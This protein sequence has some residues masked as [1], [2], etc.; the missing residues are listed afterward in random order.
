VD[1]CFPDQ[2][3]SRGEA[4]ARVEEDQRPSLSLLRST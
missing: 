2:L 3:Y 1:H 4:V